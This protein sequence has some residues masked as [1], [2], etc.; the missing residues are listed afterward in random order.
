MILYLMPSL[1]DV[2]VGARKKRYKITRSIKITTFW[3]NKIYLKKQS[4]D[5]K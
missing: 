1:H 5:S 4:L 2:S 3:F